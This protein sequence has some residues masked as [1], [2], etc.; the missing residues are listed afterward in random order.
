MFFIFFPFARFSL[1]NTIQI[2][3]FKKQLNVIEF[4]IDQFNTGFSDFETLRKYLILFE[5]FSRIS[6]CT[7]RGTKLRISGKT[8]RFANMIYL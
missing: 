4:S 5:N 1:K 2:T 8:L 7:N 3:N 6:H